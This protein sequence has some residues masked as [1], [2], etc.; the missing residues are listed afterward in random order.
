MRQDNFAD[1]RPGYNPA[2]LARARAAQK[3]Q[4]VEAQ[5]REAV[6]RIKADNP[7]P[8]RGVPA[9]PA[10][11]I[12]KIALMHGIPV[13]A[14]LG[15][16][17]GKLVTSARRECFYQIKAQMPWTSWTQVG[18][19]VGGRDHTTAMHGAAMHAEKNGL[20]PVCG[21]DIIAKRK[22]YQRAERRAA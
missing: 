22:R 7:R 15:K 21:M 17:R 8:I 11:I 2:F 13:G 1:Y 16:Y 19:W 3:A 14:I 18:G 12:G 4:R 6:E 10:A 20:S 5:K 9:R